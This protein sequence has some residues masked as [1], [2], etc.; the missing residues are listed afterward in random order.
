MDLR[1]D[2]LTTFTFDEIVELL[3]SMYRFSV[4]P[5]QE[6]ISTFIRD[7]L[8][9]WK[10]TSL[11]KGV[12]YNDMGEEDNIKGIEL[13]VI[14][15]ILKVLVSRDFINPTQEFLCHTFPGVYYNFVCRFAEETGNIN[16]LINN[17]N[18]SQIKHTR[19]LYSKPKLL[20]APSFNMNMIITRSNEDPFITTRLYNINAYK[21]NTNKRKNRTANLLKTRLLETELKRKKNIKNFYMN[22]KYVSNRVETIKKKM[23]DID[24]GYVIG[25]ELFNELVR[26]DPELWLNESNLLNKEYENK[27]KNQIKKLEFIANFEPPSNHTNSVYNQLQNG[28]KRWVK[29][30]GTRKRK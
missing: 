21:N 28:T 27:L 6:K 8:F 23:K 20:R 22:P 18:K 15:N 13:E 7:A 3:S 4:Y 30:G 9:T 5:T 17:L 14:K 1:T 10:L 19:L 26:K 11:P 12:K 29:R 25:R 24:Y 16:Q 2:T